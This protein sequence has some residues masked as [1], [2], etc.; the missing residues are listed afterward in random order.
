MG[1]EAYTQVILPFFSNNMEIGS[2][3]NKIR[4]QVRLAVKKLINPTMIGSDVTIGDIKLKLYIPDDPDKPLPA[5]IKFNPLCYCIEVS[6]Y[7]RVLGDFNV[8][9]YAW[10]YWRLITEPWIYDFTNDITRVVMNNIDI[11]Y[12]MDMDDE[13]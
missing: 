5:N 12:L 9:F 4:Q 11:K 8:V 13:K 7:G 3:F 6:K 1:A 2:Y 10:D